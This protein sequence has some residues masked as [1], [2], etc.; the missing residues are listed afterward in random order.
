VKT[1]RD[2]DWPMLVRNRDRLPEVV[3]R[4]CEHIVKEDARVIETVTALRDG[5][6]DELG[7]LF[8]ASHA[9]MRDLFEI[10]SRELDA[11]VDIA[12]SVPGV[13]AARMTGG[14][15][16]GCTVNLVT[17]GTGAAERLEERVMAEYPARTGLTPRVFTASAVDGAG[18]L[19]VASGT[20]GAA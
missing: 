8:A 7:R 1:L 15:F 19:E 5:N 2:V 11:M 9:S 13:V 17:A 18:F 14:G 12:L 10:S 3:G 20:Y 4:R 6:L 16:G